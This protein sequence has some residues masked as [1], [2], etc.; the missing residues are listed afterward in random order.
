L[1]KGYI[2]GQQGCATE[3]GFTTQGLYREKSITGEER[4]RGGD[5]KRKK[6]LPRQQ[7]NRLVGG[8]WGRSSPSWVR[9]RKV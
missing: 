2:G 3:G 1:G 6:H 8:F 7:A 4:K 5:R 9:K